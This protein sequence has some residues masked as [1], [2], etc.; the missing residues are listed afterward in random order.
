ML[1]GSI[2]A[3]NNSLVYA[4]VVDVI[5]NKVDVVIV[6][7]FQQLFLHGPAHAAAQIST[8]RG[9]VYLVFISLNLCD[10]Q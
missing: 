7:F 1:K 5:P 8:G 3:G 4:E 9:S 10:N 2:I 6:G